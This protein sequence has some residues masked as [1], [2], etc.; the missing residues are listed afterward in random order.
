MSL[1]G[2][3]SIVLIFEKGTD[4]MRARQV[5]Q[6]RLIEVFALPN[7]SKPPAMINPLSSAGRCMVIGLTSDKLSLIEMSVLTRWTIL[8]RLLGVRGVANVS[9]WGER[10][11][12][13][14]VQ[15]DPER[16][17]DKNVR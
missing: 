4:I 7:V 9:I 2:L 1:P 13:L 10:K 11:W 15:V 6:E 8:P 3:S 12:Q 17:Q 14:Q 5:A 16:L